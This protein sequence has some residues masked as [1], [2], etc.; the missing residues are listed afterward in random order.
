LKRSSGLPLFTQAQ[1]TFS[2]SKHYRLFCLT[3]NDC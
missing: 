3:T 1:E 2:Q